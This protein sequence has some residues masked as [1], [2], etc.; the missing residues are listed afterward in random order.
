[1]RRNYLGA[2]VL[3]GMIWTVAL[4]ANGQ[5]QM[6]DMPP[7]D[8]DAMLFVNSCLNCHKG[9]TAGTELINTHSRSL[10]ALKAAVTR[11]QQYT[12]PLQEEQIDALVDLL[13][14]P[15]YKFRI[16]EARLLKMEEEAAIIAAGGDNADIFAQLFVAKCAACHTVGGGFSSG[17]DLVKT[18][19]WQIPQ[20]KTAVKAMESRVGPLTDEQV[21]G[22]TELLKDREVKK[23]LASA[24]MKLP[25]PGE[26]IPQA[27]AAGLPQSTFQ[28]QQTPQP[29]IPATMTE[30]ERA[31]RLAELEANITIKPKK[32]PARRLVIL[33]VLAVLAIIGVVTLFRLEKKH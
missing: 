1:M 27:G 23:R 18:V 31:E 24:G 13:H 7:D 33:G 3:T 12:G 21:D 32:V 25:A 5:V 28:I 30:A 11:M 6:D 15:D 8:P 26:T 16:D 19:S 10:D 9:V 17:G 29:K 22:L 2:L 4:M 20:L 14:D